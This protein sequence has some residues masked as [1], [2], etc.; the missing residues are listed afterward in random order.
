MKRHALFFATALAVASLGTAGLAAAQSAPATNATA[1]GDAR[2]DAPRAAKGERPMRH[3]KGHSGHRGG[4]AMR[5]GI[6]RMDTD[7][8]GRISRAEFDAAKAAREEARAARIAQREKAGAGES[9]RRARADRADRPARDGVESGPRMGFDFDAIDTN[10]D[11][12]IVRSEVAA[13]RDRMQ[14]Q[15]RAKHAERFAEAF[16]A[17]DLNKDGKLSRVEVDEKMP[18]L[19]KRFAWTDD[20]RDGFLSRAELEAGKRR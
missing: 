15:M 5:G 9:P 7:E 20:N 8:D 6:E 16:A 11:G 3:G 19:S 12:Y 1:A 18:R 4:H 2:T 17:A 13:H 14:Q 10:K